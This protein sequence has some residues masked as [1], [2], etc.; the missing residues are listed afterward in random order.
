MD[1]LFAFFPF[2]RIIRPDL[3]VGIIYLNINET[4]KKVKIEFF[5]QSNFKDCASFIQ[6]C[7]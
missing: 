3:S 6:K 4:M 5:V 2:L 7:V 1:P